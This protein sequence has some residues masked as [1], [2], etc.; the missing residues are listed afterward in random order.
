MNPHFKRPLK[1]TLITFCVMLL[2]V[3]AGATWV[4]FS[5]TSDRRRKEYASLMGSGLGLVTFVVIAP[6]WFSAAA[7]IGKEKREARNKSS[8]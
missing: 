8:K 7:R 3:I 5:K 6:F 2:L 4:H 1:I